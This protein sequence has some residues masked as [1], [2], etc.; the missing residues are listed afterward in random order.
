MKSPNKS[1]SLDPWP[2]FL[3]LEYLDILIT[4]ITSIINASLEQGKCP[5][6]YKQAH[7]TPI[8]KKKLSL[9]KEMFKNYRSVSNLNFISK[10]LERVV[11]VQLQTH[12]DEAGLM[13]AFQSAYR[14]QNS[15]VSALLN[16]RNDILL[17]MAKGSVTALTLLDLSAAFD[18]IDHTILLDRL[19][20]YYG[21]SELALGWFKSYLPG[22]THSVKVGNTLSHP[23]ALQYGIP[24]GSVLGPILFSLY[25]N[26]ISSIIHS[27][28]SI[29]H[30]FYADDTQLYITLSPTNFS[31]FIQKLKNCLNDI[32]NFMF[33]NK[34]K[35]NPEKTEF[36]LI[37]SK[38][39]RK[40]LLPHFP[41]NILGN[42]VLP[43]QSVRN[44]GV[45][46]DSNF[47]FSDHV[48][49]VIKPTRV[50]A[51]D[52]YRIRPLLDLN[53]SVLLANALGSSR[54]DYCNSLFLSLTDSELRRL[55]LVQNSFCRVVTHSSKYSHITP[56]LKKLH[57]LPVKY[58]IQF[59]IGLITYKIL[60]QGQPVYLRELIHPYTSSRITR[61]STHK[62]KFLHTPTFDR[63]VH[64]SVKLFSNS[65]SHYA[66][67]LWNSFPFHIRNSL[68]VASFRKHL[69]THLFNFSFPT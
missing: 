13:S 28:S 58:R 30:H 20:V 15:T 46:F 40:Q 31:C 5:N 54:L 50:H 9:Y 37:G 25:T 49:Q 33:A 8:L 45:V 34:L 60:N 27:H 26:P 32:Q 47:L 6:F 55:Q 62:L 14:K 43:A 16:I 52:L 29:N 3:V 35:R 41:I 1:C 18:T 39:N 36:I 64:K 19:N 56:Q 22:G 17:N 63:K 53:T 21:I 7:V 23:A 66:P 11:A 51:R 12:L 2:T 4:P 38:N 10:I 69:K 24:Q 44:L 59:K 67:G 57:W 65:F 68:S 61:R 42:Q 48:S